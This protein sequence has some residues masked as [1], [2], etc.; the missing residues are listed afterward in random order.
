MNYNYQRRGCLL[1]YGCKDLIDV[2]KLKA[3]HGFVLL[4]PVQPELSPIGELLVP[5]RLTVRDP[6]ALLN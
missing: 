6:A 5:E 4:E 1:P 3:W 2:L